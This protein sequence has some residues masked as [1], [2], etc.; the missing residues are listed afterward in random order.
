[1]N[2]VQDVFSR[3]FEEQD[4]LVDAWIPCHHAFDAGMDYQVKDI[5]YEN[6]LVS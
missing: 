6:S 5:N 4:N 3:T 1:V 2:D